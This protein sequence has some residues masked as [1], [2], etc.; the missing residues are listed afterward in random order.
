MTIN[1]SNWNGANISELGRED[2]SSQKKFPLN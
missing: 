2:P 1:L